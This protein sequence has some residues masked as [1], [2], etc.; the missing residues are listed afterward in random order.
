MA[1]LHTGPIRLFVYGTMMRG[2]CRHAALAGQRFLGEAIS[3]SRYRLYDLGPYPAL[4]EC[5][6]GRAVI[7]ELWEVNT[8]RIPLLDR[9]ED[10]PELYRLTTIE[11]ANPPG[12][13]QAYLWQRGV[14]GLAE[15]GTRWT[16]G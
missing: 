7:G 5:E 13:A 14:E 8:D 11:L 1:A 10:A 15:C 3:A 16:K 9:I 12:E 2:C 6:D 4:V